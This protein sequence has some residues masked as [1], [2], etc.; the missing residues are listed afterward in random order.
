MAAG[1]SSHFCAIC[2]ESSSDDFPKIIHLH[3]KIGAA[4]HSFHKECMNLWIQDNDTCPLCRLRVFPQNSTIQSRIDA[5]AKR[6]LIEAGG[7]DVTLHQYLDREDATRFQE[8]F[9][10]SAIDKDLR[11]ELLHKATAKGSTSIVETLLLTQDEE[12]GDDRE[13]VINLATFHGHRKIVSLILETGDVSFRTK[14][15][16]LIIFFLSDVARLFSV[17]KGEKTFLVFLMV[18]F[19][20]VLAMTESWETSLIPPSF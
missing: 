18:T 17:S 6:E 9:Q 4:K 8:L 19:F 11:G 5:L 12:I 15:R 1:I 7:V 16:T 14:V 13:R 3:P 2:Q 10:R 20:S